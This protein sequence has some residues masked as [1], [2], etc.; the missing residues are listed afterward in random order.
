MP[1]PNKHTHVY[2]K[3]SS[4]LFP[5]GQNPSYKF[6]LYFQEFIICQPTVNI[7]IYKEGKICCVIFV[8]FQL[9]TRIGAR[10]SKTIN[11]KLFQE[12]M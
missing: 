9:S 8:I 1:I 5:G 10:D 7:C 6:L 3:L 4:K 12:E 11:W 2:C